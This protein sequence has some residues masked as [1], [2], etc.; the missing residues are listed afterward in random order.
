MYSHVFVT[1]AVPGRPLL[2]TLLTLS[3]LREFGGVLADSPVWVLHPDG[4]GEFAEMES[5][6]LAELGGELL[7]FTADPEVLKFPLGAKVQAAAVAEKRAA[8][9]ASQLIWLDEDTLILSPPAEFILEDKFSL[10]FRP[11]HHKLL[12]TSWG[13]APDEFWQQVYQHCG[14]DPEQDFMMVSHAGERIRPY[15]NAGCYA[16]RP[17]RG[18]LARWWDNFQSSYQ[19]P[20]FQSFYEENSLYAIFMHQAVLTGTILSSLDRNELKALSPSF[21]YPLHLHQDIPEKL[22]VRDVADLM[23]A[24]CESIFDQPGWKEVLPISD[25]LAAWITSRLELFS[26]SGDHS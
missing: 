18:V 11:V 4:M 21:N 9:E 5:G 17:E 19:A 26:V 25:E 24:R 7:P 3:S 14:A 6:F 12:G 20:E 16:L 1:L 2:R 23:T 15:F 22:Q 8:G 13:E 10:G